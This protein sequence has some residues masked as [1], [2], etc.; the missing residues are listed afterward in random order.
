[1]GLTTSEIAVNII[2]CCCDTKGTDGG[3]YIDDYKEIEEEDIYDDNNSI[4]GSTINSIDN[5]DDFMEDPQNEN[6]KSVINKMGWDILEATDDLWTV[7]DEIFFSYQPDKLRNA[8][9]NEETGLKKGLQH[10]LDSYTQESL[11]KSIK[12]Y[13]LH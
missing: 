13:G 7:L 4:G 5:I 2:P 6:T 12:N 10:I 9:Q 11:F 1:M 8:I 3:D